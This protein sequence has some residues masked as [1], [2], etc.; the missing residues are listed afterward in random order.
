MNL[1]ETNKE[2][3]SII[4]YL[5]E[6]FN[7]P[8]VAET[9]LFNGIEI[10][11]FHIAGQKVL[12]LN[13]LGR[14][15]FPDNPKLIY[16]V[17]KRNRSKCDLEN[18]IVIFSMKLQNDKYHGNL[19]LFITFLGVL[20]ILRL[21]KTPESSLVMDW[22]VNI[23]STKILAKTTSQQI[24]PHTTF[25]TETD[26][27]FAN[28][29]QQFRRH[30]KSLEEIEK[31]RRFDSGEIKYLHTKINAL[32]KRVEERISSQA[33][34]ISKQQAKIVR[35]LIKDTAINGVHSNT[36]Y[37]EFKKKFKIYSVENLLKTD[38]K[39]AIALF[40]A[41]Q[42]NQ[43]KKTVSKKDSTLDTWVKQQKEGLGDCT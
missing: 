6:T 41:L 21:I 36:I 10:P 33:E 31:S 42:D 38:Y 40:N 2:E 11:V 25:V 28:I 39:R 27:L 5:K 37:N 13:H 8:E 14:I 9:L 23:L 29:K 43:E 30:E 7:L 34:P 35:S 24:V 12:A 26:P 32:E 19:K 22:V 15:A 3:T 16:Q 17:V 20:K 18:D 1:N 4:P